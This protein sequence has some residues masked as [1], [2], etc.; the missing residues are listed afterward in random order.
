MSHCGHGPGPTTIGGN[1]QPTVLDPDHDVLTALERWTEKGTPP[2]SFV[3]TRYA[4][5]TRER[6]VAREIRVCPYPAN[7]RFLGGDPAQASSYDCAET[8]GQFSSDLSDER[9]RVAA[10]RAASRPENLP[11]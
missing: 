1:S 5:D 10:D 8:V 4:D 7:T 11:N 6:S 3:A 9:S 2:G